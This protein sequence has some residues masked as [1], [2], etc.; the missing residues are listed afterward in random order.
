VTARSWILLVAGG[1]LLVKSVC[2]LGWPSLIARLARGWVA[3]VR[4]VASA[5]SWVLL[6]LGVAVWAVLLRRQSAANAL[7]ALVG[8][9]LLVAAA[10]HRSAAS[11]Q[12]W[13]GLLLARRPAWLIRLAALFGLALATFMIWTAGKTR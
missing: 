12:R 2:A 1:A 10:V 13:S 6:A 9:S 8:A 3:A 11:L 4:P 7:L 5:V